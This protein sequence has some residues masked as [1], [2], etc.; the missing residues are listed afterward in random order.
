VRYLAQ[1]SWGGLIDNWRGTAAAGR[2][3][4]N[5]IRNALPDAGEY[6]LSKQPRK[7]RV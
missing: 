5:I 3:P 1:R 7:T 6:H 4:S 2:T